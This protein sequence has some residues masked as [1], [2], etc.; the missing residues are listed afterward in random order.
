MVRPQGF[1]PR[2]FGSV[3]RRSIHLSY[4][5]TSCWVHVLTGARLFES[6]LEPHHP[7]GAVSTGSPSR[8]FERFDAHGQQGRAFGGKI[9]RIPKIFLSRPK[10]FETARE[11]GSRPLLGRTAP[12]RPTSGGCERFRCFFRG[13]DARPL[14]GCATHDN[15]AGARDVRVCARPCAHRATRRA[16]SRGARALH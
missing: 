5:C 11:R 2:T 15:D 7:P 6:S 3:D 12:G 8:R 9:L 16:A 10:P 14:D 1:E 4:G 13:F